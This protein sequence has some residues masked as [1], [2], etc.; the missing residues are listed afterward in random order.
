MSLLDLAL[1]GKA[2]QSQSE[3]L[4]LWLWVISLWCYIHPVDEVFWCRT[5]IE[6]LRQIQA[7]H[8]WIYPKAWNSL[9][10]T[11]IYWKSSEFWDVRDCFEVSPSKRRTTFFISPWPL[12]G[13]C[14][15][16]KEAYKRLFANKPWS[17]KVACLSWR[18]FICVN[19]LGEAEGEVVRGESTQ[20]VSILKA[21][22]GILLFLVIPASGVRSDT[23]RVSVSAGARVL[24]HRLGRW[25]RAAF[26]SSRA[27]VIA[28]S[29]VPRVSTL[30][31]H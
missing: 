17:W 31:F 7:L 1:Q 28:S 3:L 27:V 2:Q 26:P 8:L 11:D 18:H 20:L 6:M 13:T 5:Q 21:K 15:F 23:W 30:G 29:P 25:L 19:Y 14:S 10:Q 16:W 4:S 24:R 9:A 12:L 22:M